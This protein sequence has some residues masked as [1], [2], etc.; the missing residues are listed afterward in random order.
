MAAHKRQ[1]GVK[2]GVISLGTVDNIYYNYHFFHAWRYTQIVE[3][4]FQ[5]RTFKL[6]LLMLA[7]PRRCFHHTLL[8][9]RLIPSLPIHCHEHQ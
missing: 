9:H 6:L 5:E 7:R 3:R 2:L 1:H 4:K 8:S